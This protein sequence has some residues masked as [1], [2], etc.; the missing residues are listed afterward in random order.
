MV[1]DSRISPGFLAVLMCVGGGLV[2][3]GGGCGPELE[4]QQRPAFSESFGHKFYTISCQRVAY[5]SSRRAHAADPSRPTDVSGST[6][7]RTC[8]YGPHFLPPGAAQRDPK[9]ATLA[10]HYKPM[11]QAVDLIFPGKELSD[12]QDYLVAVLPLTDN[13]AFPGLVRKGASVL[14]TMEQDSELH[15][16]LARMDGRVGYRPRDVCFGVVKELLSY[17]KMHETLGAL[18]G[19]VGEQGKGHRAFLELTEA[20]S[21][22]LR[23]TQAVHRL[24]EPIHPG[25]RDRTMRL[26]LDLLLSEDPAFASKGGKPMPIVRRDWRGV[27]QVAARSGK[28]PPPFVDLDQDGLADLDGLGN[29]VTNPKGASAPQPFVLDTRAPDSAPSRDGQ[30]RALDGAGK[31]I[32]R[33]IDADRTLMAALS[34]D[35]AEIMDPDKRT[36]T[37]LILG[38]SGLMGD[39]VP[40]SKTFPGGEKLEFRGFD[41]RQAPALDLIHGALQLLRDPAILDTLDATDQLLAKHE[42]PLTRVLDAALDGYDLADKPRYDSA[43]IAPSSTLY[44]DLIAVVQKIAAKDNGKLLE[45]LIRALGD[46]RT[47]N[48]GG[49]LAN[50]FKYRDVHQLDKD[51]DKVVNPTFTQVVDRTKPDTAHNRSIQQRLQHIINNTHG[52]KMCNKD[53][54]CIGLKLL[55]KDL[56]VARFKKCELFE[57]KN[58]ALFYMQSIAR[59]RDSKG[60]LTSTPK[61]HLRLKTENMPL[62]MSAIVKSVGTD[63]VLKLMTGIDGMSSHPTTEAINRLMFIDPLP[64]T[65]ALAQDPAVDI[66]GHQVN[67]YHV[68][69]LLSWEVPHPQYSCSNNDPCH[70]YDAIRPLIQAFADHDAEVLFLDLIRVLHRHWPS[71]QSKTHQF[72][73]PGKPDF[74]HG[75]ASVR[76]EPLIVDLMQTDLMPALSA[77]GPVL[78]KLKLSD[79]RPAKRALVLTVSFLVDPT[80]SPGLTYR[81]GTKQSK[82]NAG[83]IVAGGVSPFYLLADALAAKDAALARLRTSDRL[84]ADAWDSS[85]SDLVDIFLEVEGTGV[86]KR[87][88]NRRIVPAARLVLELARERIKAHRQ[89]GD[90]DSWLGQELPGAIERRL[91]SPVVARAADFLR[92]VEQDTRVRDAIY[93]LVGYLIDEANRNPTFRATVSGIVDMVQLLLDDADIVPVLRAFGE[94]LSPKNGLMRAALRFLDP[95]VALDDNRTLCGILRNAYK[96]QSPGKSPIQTLLDLATELHRVKPGEGTPYS[97]ADFREALAQSRDFLEN[98]HT[99]LEKFFEIVKNRCG[100]PCPAKQQ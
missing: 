15:W 68:G 3:L 18:L 48:L 17:D 45:D 95:A 73:A 65:L 85:T 54:A 50:Y 59:L 22:E 37:N 38:L 9:V 84:V 99:G 28:I 43:R 42:A 41:T 82:T 12:L 39:R 23:S 30:G 8:K 91:S 46:P 92:I 49:M 16:A 66:D 83:E 81:D 56:C 31:L 94:A 19:L 55:G 72:T 13:D 76:Y 5:T 36:G 33:Y 88:K 4:P 60:Q 58:G 77:L 24:P 57:V 87:F 78:D 40:A 100:G 79:G 1:R 52:M 61:A 69:S 62:W 75:T 80:R 34:R 29:Y 14:R 25:A 70:F 32:Y 10:H 6:Y 93:G 63:A 47:K 97:G 11:V 71:K 89:L 98:Q 2:P 86:N 64:T 51:N 53:N 21:A 67:T 44:D 20:L 27:A 90:S 35:A 96:E 7:R 26:A 74:A